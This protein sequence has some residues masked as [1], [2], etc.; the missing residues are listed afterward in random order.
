M[1]V[2]I[3]KVFIGGMKLI[4]T[5]NGEFGALP[6]IGD[7]MY[8]SISSSITGPISDCASWHLVHRRAN[9][10]HQGAEDQIGD[11]EEHQQVDDQHRVDDA[12][13]RE[14]IQRQQTEAEI[15]RH[16]QQT[17]AELPEQLA[18]HQLERRHGR[19]QHFDDAAGLLLDRRGHQRLP[20]DD[21]A[22]EQQHPTMNGSNAHEL[23]A[24][25][26]ARRPPSR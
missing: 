17:D 26:A 13:H 19:E 21:D 15:D 12:E 25:P 3:A 4:A 24:A 6:I 5:L 20:A 9:R 18:R 11:Q 2:I 22:D 1:R 14:R 16:R 23:R 10:H 7:S 8:G